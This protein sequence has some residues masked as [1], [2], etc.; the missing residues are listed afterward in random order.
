MQIIHGD[1]LA[2]L[3]TLPADSI[4]AVAT[5]P[6]YE[7]NFMGRRWDRTGVAFRPE[8]WAAVA[9]AMKPG[10]HLVAFGGARTYHRLA[11]AIEDAGF[12]IR[13]AIMW[14][15]G[16]GFPKSHDVSKALDRAAGAERFGTNGDVLTISATDAAR[17]WAGWGTA[18]KPA[19]EIIVLARK[20]LS[21][22]TIA[23]NVLRWGT[24]ALHIDACRVPA[25][26]P[27]Q[28]AAGCVGFG[29]RDDG[30]K[31]GTG[32]EYKTSARWPPNMAHDG[33]TEVMQAFARFGEHAAGGNIRPSCPSSKTQ[34]IYGEFADRTC[35]GSYLDTGTAARFFYCAKADD[36]DRLGSRHPTVKPVALMRW[37]VRLITPPGGMVLDPFAGSGTTGMACLAEGVDCVLIEREAEYVADIKARLAHVR[38]DDTPLFAQ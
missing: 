24:G 15:Y 22:P 26:E 2:V 27:V 13:D 38:G 14:H 23:A 35:W 32:R 37:L 31:A 10:A 34:A 30:Y 28:S 6:P 18:L 33:S 21:E 3:P 17:Q 16:S 5:D 25:S 8:T 1:C 4:D 19:T 29:Q 20:P 12:E 7:L 9:L 11:C 36:S